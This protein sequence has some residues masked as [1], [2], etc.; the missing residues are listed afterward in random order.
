[1]ISDLEVANHANKGDYCFQEY[2]TCNWIYH[3]RSSIDFLVDNFPKR[4]EAA[5][6]A[7]YNLLRRLHAQYYTQGHVTP[8]IVSFAEQRSLLKTELMELAKLYRAE[9][10]FSKDPNNG[11]Y[12]MNEIL[13]VFESNRT[14]RTHSSFVDA[15]RPSSSHYRTIL[16]SFIHPKSRAFRQRIWDC[17]IQMLDFDL[18]TFS[19]WLHVK[20]TK[21]CSLETAPASI[22]V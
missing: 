1:M 2:A 21:R 4:E 10:I 14:D 9:S 19:G 13:I 17:R 12:R 7:S 11:M 16:A 20:T 6:K 18:L 5:F 15:D 8:E 22:Q 3:L